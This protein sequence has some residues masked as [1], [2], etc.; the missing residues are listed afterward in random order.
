MTALSN[1]DPHIPIKMQNDCDC[2]FV[3]SWLLKVAEAQ[4]FW[5]QMSG[6]PPFENSESAL[7]WYDYPSLECVALEALGARKQ[8]D[9][10]FESDQPSNVRGEFYP[11]EFAVM[12]QL[13][14]FVLADQTYQMTVP[15]SVTFEQVQRAALKAAAINA[16]DDVAR[17]D[18]LL[19]TLSQ[20]EAEAARCTRLALLRAGFRDF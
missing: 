12:I 11:F 9:S 4:S 18:R 3:G 8:V 13:G 17:R 5:S 16:H 2:R 14:F 7:C 15:D 6:H 10:L 1:K 19:H 20:A